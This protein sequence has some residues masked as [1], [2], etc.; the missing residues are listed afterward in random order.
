MNCKRVR[1]YILRY[2]IYVCV[3]VCVCQSFLCSDNYLMCDAASVDFDIQIVYIY[4]LSFIMHTH[5]P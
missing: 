5:P 4:N 2:T 3:Y 1:I